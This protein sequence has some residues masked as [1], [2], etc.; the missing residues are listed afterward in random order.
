MSSKRGRGGKKGYAAPSGAQVL[1]KRSAQEAGLDDRNLGDITK[2][3]ALFPELRWHSNGTMWTEDDED[4][5]MAATTT[6]RSSSTVYLIQKGRELRSRM[7]AQYQV[8]PTEKQD[9]MRYQEKEQ[10]DASV[11]ASPLFAAKRLGPAYVPAE[12]LQTAANKKQKK[13]TGSTSSPEKRAGA[14]KKKPAN[15]KELEEREQTRSTDGVR[16]ED[17]TELDQNHEQQSDE[18]EESADYTM[19]YYESEGEESDGGGG[20]PTF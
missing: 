15:F 7:Q 5:D 11:T 13:A 6:K 4:D 3:G 2:P 8:R 12:L 17:A 20:E 1:L 19:N 10:K 14:Q 9:V 16:E 18:E